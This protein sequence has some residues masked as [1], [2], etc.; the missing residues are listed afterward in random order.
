MN[1]HY[2]HFIHI[3]YITNS[4]KNV[5]PTQFFSDFSLY[6]KENTKYSSKQKQK[7][8]KAEQKNP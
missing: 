2:F 3:L 8:N 4:D 1:Q 5:F 7:H 6:I